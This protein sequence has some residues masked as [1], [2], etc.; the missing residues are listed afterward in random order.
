MVRAPPRS[1]LT[2]SPRS[3]ELPKPLERTGG[4]PVGRARGWAPVHHRQPA[5][6]ARTKVLDMTAKAC[7]SQRLRARRAGVRRRDGSR[8]PAR[9][10]A[11]TWISVCVQPRGGR[12]RSGHACEREQE[13]AGQDGAP[14]CLTSPGRLQVGGR[15]GG[16]AP[17]ETCT[18]RRG[19]C[20]R[21]RQG[22]DNRHVS[23]SVKA[24]LV[25]QRGAK[26]GRNRPEMCAGATNP[27]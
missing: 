1:V 8:R 20:D 2:A 24:T 10:G 3:C 6:R 4:R 21:C 26:R 18:A 19:L 17:L 25:T 16:K 12:C 13:P 23:V 11:W 14:Q 9:A 22:S 5:P 15:A 7:D 27:A